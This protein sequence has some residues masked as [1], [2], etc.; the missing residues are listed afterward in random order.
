MSDEERVNRG[1]SG[2]NYDALNVR[3][4][5]RDGY[6]RMRRSNCLGF[7][8]VAPDPYAGKTREELIAMLRAK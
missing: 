5:T 3:G 2:R 1:G 4:A 7:R 6:A 8:C